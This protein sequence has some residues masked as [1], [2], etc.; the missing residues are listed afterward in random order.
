MN[1]PARVST[2]MLIAAA[3]ILAAGDQARDALRARLAR[4]CLAA[5]G[6]AG[7]RLLRLADSAAGRM[8]LRLSE[9]AVLPGI[10]AHYG[11]R[12]RHLWRWVHDDAVAGTR[13]LLVLGAGFD[14]LGPR[15]A[16]RHRSL[17]VF[18]VDRP[19]TIAIRTRALQACGIPR[20]RLALR[21]AD[22]AQDRLRDTLRSLG[23]DGFDRNAPT[24][25]VAEGLLMYLPL[26]AVAALYDDLRAHCRAPAS[27]VATAMECDARGAPGFRRQ[28]PWLQ[29]WLARRGEPFAW[30]AARAQLPA[31][32]AAAGI[33]L[34]ETIDPETPRDP[35]P[36]PG[37][38]LFRGTLH[39]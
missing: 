37:E 16:A 11:W 12:K 7:R 23:A 31:V 13:Q 18:E 14:A 20:S 21:A 8:L 24:T 27:V 30:G 26:P 29:R 6:D 36:C 22:F 25:V 33:A 9:F 4:A 5:C 10:A 1:A 28:R 15:M 17:R 32:M 34:R 19:G 39:R 2:S 38:W 35:D 3:E